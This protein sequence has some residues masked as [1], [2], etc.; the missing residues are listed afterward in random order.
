MATLEPDDLYTLRNF[1]WL[2][3]YQLAIN[4]ANRLNR[5][6]N[7][8]AIEKDEFVYRCY[9][10]L[11]QYNI[12]QSEIKDSESTP[13]GL[14]CVKLLGQYVVANN[15]SNEASAAEREGL[16][17]TLREMGANSA[18]ASHRTYLLVA[19]TMHLYEGGTKEA[20]R[21][22]DSSASIEHKVLCIQIFLRMNRL[23]LAHAKLKQLKTTDGAEEHTLTRLATCWVTITEGD[24]ARMKEASYIYEEL[25]DKYTASCVLLNGQAVAEM[26]QGN[27]AKAEELLNDSLSKTPSDPDSLANLVVVQQHLQ[28]PVE[29]VNRTL[30][31]LALRAPNHPLVTTLNTFDGAFERLSAAGAAGGVTA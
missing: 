21:Y 4:E 30:S 1:F 12:L 10:A 20:L 23:D 8:L 18:V 27:W 13:I 3:H 29:L 9:L 28:R 19:A 7:A 16:M 25:M 5:L 26:Q 24:K 14:R 31:Q 17:S 22:I 6:P 11:G 15:T 2:G